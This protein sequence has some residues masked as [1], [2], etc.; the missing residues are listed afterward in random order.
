MWQLGWF[1]FPLIWM[2]LIIII[3]KWDVGVFISVE[4]AS[5]GS[6]ERVFNTSISSLFADLSR[7]L[8][9]LYHIPVKILRNTS[10]DNFVFTNFKAQIV[11]IFLISSNFAAFL[12][13]PKG[14]KMYQ[15]RW[16]YHKKYIFWDLLCRTLRVC[17]VAYFFII[18]VSFEI[19]LLLV[20][21]VITSK[22]RSFMLVTLI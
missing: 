12:Y 7:T 8:D 3:I 22:V 14:N 20:T 11:L 16:V 6:I 9:Y 4:Q 2:Y 13:T 17:R 18:P 10:S 21:R 5:V 15:E 1:Y 19:K